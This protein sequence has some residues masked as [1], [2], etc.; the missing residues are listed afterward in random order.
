MAADLPFGPVGQGAASD[1]RHYS[2]GDG[3]NGWAGRLRPA[4]A[5]RVRARPVT[6]R[7]LSRDGARPMLTKSSRYGPP[8]PQQSSHSSRQPRSSHRDEPVAPG[9]V[10]YVWPP[11]PVSLLPWVV[12]S[13]GTVKRRAFR[14]KR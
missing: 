12:A 3:Q 6:L 8:V 2:I 7:D 5:S 14:Q 4:T 1:M 13:N 10:R 9:A 11:A